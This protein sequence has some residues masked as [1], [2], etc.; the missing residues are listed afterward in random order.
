MVA[1]IPV[2]VTAAAQARSSASLSPWNGGPSNVEHSVF[3][4]GKKIALPAGTLQ[5]RTTVVLTN[6]PPRNHT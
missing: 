6:E 5:L 3:S 1:N 2:F 4:T